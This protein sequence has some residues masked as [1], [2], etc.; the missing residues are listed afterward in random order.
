[1]SPPSKR[2]DIRWPLRAWLAVEVCFGLAAM[3]TIALRPQDSATNFAWPISPDVSAALLGAFYL[4]SAW[5]FVLALT[6]RRWEQIRVMM[7]PA[8]VFTSMELLATLLHWD[9]FSVG[10]TPF[11]VWFASYLLPPPILTAC[12]LWQRRGAVAGPAR[13]PLPVPL[14][15]T[16]TAAGSLIVAFAVAAFA[17]P[18]LLIEAA[19]WAFTPLTTRA[20]CGW[21]AALG[22]MLALGGRDGD[23]ARLLVLSPFFVLIGPAVALQ[24][25]RFSSQ[26]D[27]THPAVAVGAV[28]LLAVGAC[29]LYL[30]AGDWHGFFA[31]RSGPTEGAHAD[32]GAEISS[33]SG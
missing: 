29:G 8:I 2:S 15:R 17:W 16:M 13:Q 26:V 5:V 18:T 12:A 28:V 1:M 31:L 32:T 14:A 4:S 11:A 20:V 22:L 24:C 6:A 21:L 23:R 9:K 19:P 10:T 27:W 30:A 25:A 3:S 7:V 33:P